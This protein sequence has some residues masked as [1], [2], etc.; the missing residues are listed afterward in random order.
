MRD[1]IEAG[2]I[3]RTTLYDPRFEHDACGVGAVATLRGGPSHAVVTRALTV[4]ENLHHRGA[5]LGDDATGD[6]AGILLQIPHAIFADWLRRRRANRY[7]HPG[8]YAVAVCYLPYTAAAESGSV[9]EQAVRAEGLPVIGW[10]EIPTDQSILGYEA[11]ASMPALAQLIV[12]RPTTRDADDFERACYRARKAAERALVEAELRGYLA[13]FSG[14]T[15]VYKGM[16]T[17]HQLGRFFLDLH[18]Q[19]CASQVAVTH[20][21]FSTNTFPSWERAQP[22]R[23]LCHNGEINT[24]QRQRQ[25]GQS[26]RGRSAGNPPAGHRRAGQRFRDARQHAGP[27]GPRRAR[28]APRHRH[29][30]ARGLGGQHRPAAGSA[31]LLRVPRDPDRALGWPGGALLHRRPHPRR[32]PRPQR[33]APAALQR[34]RRRP[35]GDRERGRGRWSRTQRDRR[36]W[37]ARPRRDA[38]HRYPRRNPLA[39]P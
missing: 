37:P 3:L 15:I 18:D 12:G 31:R 30:R 6:G 19:R 7:A 17:G 16:L 36:A 39:Q 11:R 1:F 13:S 25:L 29:A 2:N 23:L 21:R 35:A 10:R 27:P 4:L 9:I 34:E 32:G 24:L 26:P 28:P 8:D 14:R 5:T 33:P 22:F 20:T 38:G